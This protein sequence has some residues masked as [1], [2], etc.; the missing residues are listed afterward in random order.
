MMGSIAGL[1]R[2]FL[3]ALDPEVA[4]EL[5][6]RALELGAYPRCANR[7]YGAL[8]VPLWGLTFP[9]P[10]GI[11]AGFDKDA[12]VPDAILGLGC[13]FA[14]VGTTTPKPASPPSCSARS[15][16]PPSSCVSR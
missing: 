8:V 5:T 7:A 11:A 2:P 13:G 10:V 15:V 6:L 16:S 1:A 12:R 4:H 3:L 14:E 9:N